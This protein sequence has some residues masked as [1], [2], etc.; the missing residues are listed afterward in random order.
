L[1]AFSAARLD[2]AMHVIGEKNRKLS[3]PR[4]GWR[5]DR[6]KSQQKEEKGGSDSWHESSWN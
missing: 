4:T 2:F 6:E 1:A 5:H 3:S